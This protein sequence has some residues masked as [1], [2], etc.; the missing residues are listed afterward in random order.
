MDVIPLGYVG[1][2][3]RHRF[4]FDEILEMIMALGRK[5]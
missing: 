1:D 4:V 2:V 5:R 3:R